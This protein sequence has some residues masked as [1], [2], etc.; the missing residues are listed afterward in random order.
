VTDLIVHTLN[1]AFSEFQQYG[2]IFVDT[3]ITLSNYGIDPDIVEEECH[4][5]G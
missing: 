4:R 2:L 5:H 1:T 3:M